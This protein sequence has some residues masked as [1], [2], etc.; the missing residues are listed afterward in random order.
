MVGPALTVLAN[1]TLGDKTNRGLLCMLFSV[2][3]VGAVRLVAA[4]LR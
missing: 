4:F 2:A 3:A 1:F